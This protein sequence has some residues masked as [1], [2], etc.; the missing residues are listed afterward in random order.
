MTQAKGL[1]MCTHFIRVFVR[2]TPP[3]AEINSCLMKP[4]KDQR[5]C[6]VL[7]A[8]LPSWCDVS[9]VLSFDLPVWR[10]TFNYNIVQWI[11]WLGG[12]WRTQLTACRNVNCRI[13]EH[14][15]FER[16]LRIQLNIESMSDSGSFLHPSSIALG[17]AEDW[18][19][20]LGLLALSFRWSFV[21]SV[22]SRCVAVKSVA[23]ADSLRCALE[24]GSRGLVA[25]AFMRQRTIGSN[26]YF[27]PE[28]R[29]DYPPNLSILIS[30]GKENNSDYLSNSEWNGTSPT[31]NY[32]P[33]LRG[34]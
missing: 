28:S 32:Q 31:L 29:Q 25:S 1:L 7:F 11:T 21:S 22:T 8:H 13:L 24:L 17:S 23:R 14:R 5:R 18:A 9:F 15:H 10:K 6:S 33:R 3:P 16:I 34:M 19:N 30:G 12:R 4:F 27:R 20:P 2:L 26:F